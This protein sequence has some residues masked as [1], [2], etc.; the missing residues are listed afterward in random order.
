MLLIDDIQFISGKY[1]FQEE[2]FHTFE[3]LHRMNKQIV[4]CSDRPPKEM[5]HLEDRLRSRF[6]SGIIA[7]VQEP[8]FETK[9]AILVQKA[10]ELKAN[11]LL[12]YSLDQEIFHFIASR[13][14]ADIRQLQ[15]AL[16]KVIAYSNLMNIEKV[17]PEIASDALK[18]YFADPNDQRRITPQ[19]IID[20]VCEHFDISKEEI[21]SKKKS[22]DVARPRQI[23]MYLIRMLFADISLEKIGEVFGGKDHTTV[24]HAIEK[25]TKEK[26]QDLETEKLLNNLVDKIKE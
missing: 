19:H 8:N 20:T 2:F 17:T 4:I 7:D 11:G 13:A 3:A 6:E 25:I 22:R 23:A 24:M 14:N 16:K 1:G 9:V 15:G 21:R 5:A 12:R 26:V 18:N 10:E